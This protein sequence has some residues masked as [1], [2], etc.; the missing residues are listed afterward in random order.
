LGAGV[1]S[2]H[3]PE[4]AFNWD[5]GAAADPDNRQLLCPYKGIE[6]GLPDGE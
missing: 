3:K 5:Q 4:K 6:G 1:S 2:V